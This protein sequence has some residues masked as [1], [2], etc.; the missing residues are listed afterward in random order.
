M[1]RALKFDLKIGSQRG[2]SMSVSISY[3]FPRDRQNWSGIALIGE[4]P[5]TEE[6]KLGR[7]FV[8]RSGQLLDKI[9]EKAGILRRDCLIANVFRF[10]PPNNK[11]GH[12]FVSRRAAKMEAIAIAEEYGRFGSAWCRKE[13]AGE[14]ENLRITLEKMAPTIIVALGRTP[15]WALTGE[16][17]LISK[18]GAPLPCR[19][20]P[21]THVIPAYHPS[22]I[23]RG[24]WGLQENWLSHFLTAKEYCK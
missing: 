13:F 20:V 1:Q 22:Y 15:L 18:V 12:F 21:K 23:L 6:V 2:P 24:N 4:A 11:V 5:G 8:G 3:D 19:L 16:N 9:L 7:P 17:G 14:I 10:Q